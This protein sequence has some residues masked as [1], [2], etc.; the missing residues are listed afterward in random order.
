MCSVVI[1][2]DRRGATFF[3]SEMRV[4]EIYKSNSLITYLLTLSFIGENIANFLIKSGVN[5]LAC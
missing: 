1:S 2:H 3:D 5:C 4:I